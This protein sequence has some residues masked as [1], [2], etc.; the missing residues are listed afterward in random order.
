VSEGTRLAEADRS[1][2]LLIW[3]FYLYRA[4][5]SEGFVYPIIT[6]Y[7]LS[8][9]LSEGGVG[10]VNGLFFVGVVGAEIPTGYVGDKIGRRNSL[11][12]STVLMS[13]S[14]LAFTVSDSLVSF[15][16]VFVFWG[17]ALTFRSGSGSAYLYDLLD[18]RLDTDEYSTITGRGGAAF[19]VTSAVTSIAGGFLYGIDRRIPF[20]AA[21]AVTASGALVLLSMPQTEQYAEGDGGD[22][23]SARDAWTVVKE[24]FLGPELRT[25]I[26]Y[27][28]LL[29][30]IPE[31][32]DLYIQ[33]I[34]VEAGVPENALGFLYAAFMLL[35][36][37]AS[38]NI[39]RVRDAI[40]IPGWFRVAPVLLAAV[41]AGMVV[42]PWLAIPGFV[43]MRVVKSLS[44]A[45]RGQY[46]N[47][48]LPSLGRA[49]VLST[50]S[51][52]YGVSFVVFRVGGG[53][54]ADAVGAKRAIVG[55]AVIV[56]VLTQALRLVGDPVSADEPQ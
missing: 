37:F 44:Y 19:L 11:I 52:V 21:G 8:R 16:A 56:M 42:T 48:R 47:D 32:A 34:V 18:E 40:G 54:V 28:A 15:A 55:L 51:M 2:R 45:F 35:T 27:T 39:D 23:F 24:K 4:T 36:A 46:L 10:F 12:V 1:E 38:Y 14:L 13:V 26:V 53:A 41:L 22:T 7:L 20:V 29:L 50:A 43:G 30:S 3:K 9:G 25:F 6:L 33:P 5:L 49:T 17:V 31:L